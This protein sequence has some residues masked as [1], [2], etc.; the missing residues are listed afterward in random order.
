MPQTPTRHPAD[1]WPPTQLRIDPNSIEDSS[2][3]SL[4]MPLTYFITPTHQGNSPLLDL[5]AGIE[6]GPTKQPVLKDIS[7]ASLLRSRSYGERPQEQE[8][9]SP[10]LLSEP[11][12]DSDD[13]DYVRFPPGGLEVRKCPDETRKTVRKK[14]DKTGKR[15]FTRHTSPP[16]GRDRGR[17]P[18]RDEENVTE[19]NQG[20][21]RRRAWREP[22][23]YVWSI[24]EEREEGL[25]NRKGQE[26][27]RKSVSGRLAPRLLQPEEPVNEKEVE[28]RLRKRK[29]RFVLPAKE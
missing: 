4:E 23:P 13:E 12:S 2:V 10:P 14:S 9:A 17:A 19:R 7:T 20:V 26:V 15:G 6:G 18:K 16:A 28:E 1:S 29:V 8:R 3:S 22:S 27:R 11:S 21:R 5:Y 25:D 24:N